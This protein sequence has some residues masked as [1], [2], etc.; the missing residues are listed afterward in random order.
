MDGP[1]TPL[2]VYLR[3]IFLA[4]HTHVLCKLSGSAAGVFPAVRLVHSLLFCSN[5]SCDIEFN[6]TLPNIQIVWIFGSTYRKGEILKQKVT[7]TCM[8]TVNCFTV[9]V[10][11]EIHNGVGVTHTVFSW[12]MHHQHSSD[13][14][15]NVSTRWRVV[16]SI[17][18]LGSMGNVC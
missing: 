11:H 1:H 6:F 10:L 3:V 7:L 12:C 13:T 5:L 2:S 18:G 17:L 8:S 16:P 15:T 14:K 4:P 9:K